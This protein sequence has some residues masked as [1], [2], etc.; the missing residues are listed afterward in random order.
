M[1]SKIVF[2]IVFFSLAIL[3][4]IITPTTVFAYSSANI[5]AQIGEYPF[6][7]PTETSCTQSGSNSTT[8]V[9]AGTLPA[10]IPEPYNGAFTQGAKNHNV[11][12]ALVAA[13]FSE[14]HNIGGSETNP[15]TA[16][17]PVAWAVFATQKGDPNSGWATSASG[18][19][20]PFQF[21]PSTWTGLGYNI[22]DINNLVIASDAAAK[23]LASN[24]ATVNTP[25]Q[26]WRNAIFAYNHADWYVNAVL[27]Y[28]NYYNSQPAATPSGNVTITTVATSNCVT[29]V[30]NCSIQSQTIQGLS[31]VR[32][33]VVCLT[34]AEWNKWQSGQLKPGIAGYGQYSQQTQEEWCAD[35]A[36]WIYD[37]AQYPLQP[38]P[39]WRVPAVA[40]I[41]SIGEQNQKFHFHNLVDPGQPDYQP[42]YVPKPGDLA[43]VNWSQHVQVV[44]D[45]QGK[46]L[47]VIGGDENGSYVNGQ[48]DFNTS[49]VQEDHFSSYTD[50]GIIGY[51]S[52][53]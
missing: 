39:N 16:T 47:T 36:S 48:Y 30:T 18:A 22:N 24:G 8:S 6:Y 45:V 35:F 31:T 44:I 37:Q 51:V 40:T 12:P 21:L 53:D 34:E 5:E 23:Y 43:I 28:Y 2:K 46:S 29:S 33:N 52:P 1:R 10:F 20:G 49:I 42:T 7:D 3:I 38:D 26:S 9:P 32:Q 13:I 15:N 4:N 19:E 41:T 27:Q 17:L 14:E 50:G 11:A 25:E